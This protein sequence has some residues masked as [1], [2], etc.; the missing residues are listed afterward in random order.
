MRAVFT[1]L[2]CIVLLCIVSTGCKEEV[3]ELTPEPLSDYLS[4]QPGKFIIYKLDSTVFTQNGRTLEVHSYQEKVL[5]DQE[6][7][8]N[9]G[10]PSFRI[11][12]FLRDVAGQNPWVSAGSFLVTPGTTQTEII[13]DNLRSVRMILPM[14]VGQTWKGNRFLPANPYASVFEF[15]DDNHI[16]L[17]DWEFNYAAKGESLTL[18]GKTVNDVLT[19]EGPDIS[20]NAGITDPASF[21]SRTLL[22]D[23][24]A[25]NIGLVY[26]EYVMWEYQP[27]PGSSAFRVGFGIKRSMLDHN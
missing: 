3:Q 18:N 19:I 9:L 27:N 26:Q 8:D 10:R 13:E 20:V 16:H 7:T 21:G 11:Y 17:E 15:S 12:R 1:Y 5:V 2:S 22:L 25:K 14:N 23:K 6:I 4:P 24:Y